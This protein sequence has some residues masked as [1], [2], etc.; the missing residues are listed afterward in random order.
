MTETTGLINYLWASCIVEE[1]VRNGITNFCVSPGSRCT[2]LT[3]AIANHTSVDVCVHF[4]ERGTA[5]FALGLIRACSKPTVLVATSGTAVANYFPAVVEA[6]MDRLPLIILTA[7]R[8]PEL[9]HTGANQTIDQIK[10]FGD[11]CRWYF[12]IPCPTQQ[13]PLETVLTT[14][15]Q[16]VHR[17]R[18]APAGPVHLN[19]MYREPFLPGRL[20]K[21]EVLIDEF[22]STE[23]S[24]ELSSARRQGITNW[25]H[26]RQPYTQYAQSDMAV[27]ENTIHQLSELVRK[28]PNGLLIVGRL[29]CDQDRF[30]VVNFVKKLGWPTYVDIT[31]GLRFG[32]TQPN[33]IHYFDLLLHI[34]EFSK[35]FTPEIVLQLGEKITSKRLYQYVKSIPTDHYYLATNDPARNN[36]EHVQGHQLETDLAKFCQELSKTLP[37]TSAGDFRSI[38]NQFSGKIDKILDRQIDSECAI[39]EP[40]VARLI[41][42]HI[43]GGTG[44]FI[45]SSMPVRDMDLFAAANGKPVTIGTNRGAS[46]IDGTIA[47]AVGFAKG[48]KRP[49]TLFIGDLA[50]LHDLNSLALVKSVKV[51]LIIIVVNNNGGGIFSFLPIATH[52]AIF[53]KYFGTPHNLSF[54]RAAELFGFSYS[55]PHDRESFIHAYRDAVIANESTLIEVT[56]D[57]QNNVKYHGDLINTIVNQLQEDLRGM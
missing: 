51:Q 34:P 5:F 47:S 54:Q 44:L 48:I 24:T 46:G 17:S 29:H 9:R 11:Y 10:I 53:E 22:V 55:H 18:R 52:S 35:A 57:R 23:L 19:C 50:F 1:F 16:A 6:A 32:Y 56:T 4:D 39:T 15:D 40:A 2:P 27:S 13:I 14:I 28:K 30:A 45:A 43:P 8:P 33:I 25:H 41:S 12:D 36:P 20:S 3:A 31:S 21:L 7:D 42:E 49:V 37:D 38:L 26:T